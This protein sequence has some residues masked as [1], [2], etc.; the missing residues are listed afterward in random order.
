MTRKIEHYKWK[1]CTNC[2]VRNCKKEP[3]EKTGGH[4]CN[5][6]RGYRGGFK[7]IDVAMDNNPIDV[8]LIAYN[9]GL[10]IKETKK[11]LTTVPRRME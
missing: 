1:V 9:A 5:K 3:Q 2:T 4:Y 6:R 8:L 7:L 11:G 10:K